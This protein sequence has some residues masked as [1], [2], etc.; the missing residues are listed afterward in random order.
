MKQ[1][2]DK[3]FENQ[4]TQKRIERTDYGYPSHPALL[5]KR[6]LINLQWFIDIRIPFFV[7]LFSAYTTFR[8][9]SSSL[10]DTVFP[11]M[12][13][14]FLYLCRSHGNLL[15]QPHNAITAELQRLIVFLPHF[16]ENHATFWPW[17]IPGYK[18]CDI[19]LLPSNTTK[20]AV[21]RIYQE[22]AEIGSF[23]YRPQMCFSYLTYNYHQYL[24]YAL[25][26][27]LFFF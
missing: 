12:E 11:Q 3:L 26:G 23:M 27:I 1:L 5:V 4:R 6:K 19:H 9:S 22:S 7:P 10:L 25:I 20:K 18:N 2:D 14:L 21:W 15:R 17:R 8:N 13:S 24:W 16:A